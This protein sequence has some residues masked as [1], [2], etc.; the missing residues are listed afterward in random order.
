VDVDMISIV[1]F[2][3]HVHLFVMIFVSCRKSFASDA[4][5]NHKKR[6]LFC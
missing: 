5:V 3:I 4:L 6:Y 1:Q 2:S